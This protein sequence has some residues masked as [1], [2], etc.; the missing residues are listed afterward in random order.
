MMKLSVILN[1]LSTA[2]R[3][4]SSNGQSVLNQFV[5]PRF[6]DDA[7]LSAMEQSIAL[8]GSRGSGKTTFISY[9]S[10]STKFDT[11][12]HD[13]DLAE[14]KCIV[15]YWK[16]DITYLQGLSPS[17]LGR[18]SLKFFSVHASLALIKEVS[19]AVKNISSHFPHI[20]ENITTNSN[21]FRALSRITCTEVTNLDQLDTWLIE[22]RY[23]LST[24]I[25]NVNT[26]GMISLEPRETINYLIDSLRYDV[27]DL[28]NSVFKIYVDEFESLTEEQQKVINTYRKHSS[29]LNNWNVAYKTNA[30]PT[31]ETTGHEWL[32][33]PDDYR[34]IVLDKLLVDDYSVHASEILL[35]S[36]LNTGLKSDITN[37]EPNWL[38]DRRNVEARCKS[39]Y[40][41]TL[42]EY[43]RNIFPTLSIKEISSRA[44][45]KQS[46]KSKIQKVLTSNQALSEDDVKSILNNPSLAMTYYGTHKQASFRAKDF[47]TAANSSNKLSQTI[48]D[49]I[50]NY[51]YNT[52]LS[53][54]LHH[55]Y[56]DLPVYSGF[57]RFIQMSVPNVRH[58]NELCYQ[59]IRDF[60]SNNQYAVDINK[61]EEFPSLGHENTHR[62]AIITSK[63][64]VSEIINYPPEGRRLSSLVHRVG[65]LFKISQKSEYQS[66]PERTI[67]KI[68]G[69]YGGQEEEIEKIISSAMSWRVLIFQEARRT[70]SDTNEASREFKLNPIYAPSFGIS[71]RSI[72]SVTFPAGDFNVM[73]NGEEF[74]FNQLRKAYLK[75]WDVMGNK[76]QM[77]LI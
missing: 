37:L 19:S 13:V 24:R 64:L 54:N 70:K 73:L 75:K 28:E 9:F 48:L 59:S 34:E 44:L 39:S 74:E 8:V 12:Q 2:R 1:S 77:D 45:E 69:D 52:Q 76:E 26:D 68:S 53:W 47:I 40:K 71:I 36:L 58:F 3:E 15:L 63:A 72:R 22:T 67:F 43:S 29:K 33:Q 7:D 20:K 55:S 62:G 56:H 65:G 10:H 49:K 5:V 25:N 60:D 46:I 6:I 50:K 66:E 18:D 23:D 38:G 11:R 35:L 21:F 30:Q 57:D 31:T 16:P 17:W 4:Y 51:E 61:I 41:N 14:L 27:S 32:Q 42:L